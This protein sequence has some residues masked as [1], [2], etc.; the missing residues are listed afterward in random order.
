[1]EVVEV[2]TRR[3]LNTGQWKTHMRR[4]SSIRASLSNQ[5]AWRS[6]HV[7][8]FVEGRFSTPRGVVRYGS[9]CALAAAATSEVDCVNDGFEDDE[10][11]FLSSFG[12]PSVHRGALVNSRRAGARATSAAGARRSIEY[13]ENV[14]YA[15]FAIL[16]N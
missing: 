16:D 4:R 5:T 7:S 10:G 15:Y 2:A 12:G 6:A 9:G 3:F 13:V 8:F 1:M 14:N 11:S